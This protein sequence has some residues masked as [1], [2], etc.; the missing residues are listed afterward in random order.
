[1][2]VCHLDTILG[3]DTLILGTLLCLV[4]QF[5]V[6]C[7]FCVPLYLLL[8]VCEENLLRGVC[9]GCGERPLLIGYY[10]KSKA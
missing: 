7:Y 9:H 5:W 6:I 1:M 8:D 3:M 10:Y 4:M 2:H